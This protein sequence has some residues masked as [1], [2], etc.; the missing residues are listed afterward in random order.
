M[1]PGYQLTAGGEPMPG[2]AKAVLAFFKGALR[3][4]LYRRANQTLE[5][6]R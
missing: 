6:F 2:P 4:P 3:H 5:P 1:R